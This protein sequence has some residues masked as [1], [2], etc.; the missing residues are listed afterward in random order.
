VG[1]PSGGQMAF[2]AAASAAGTATF[3]RITNGFGN[4]FQGSVGVGSGELQLNTLTIALGAPIT[5]TAFSVILS[6]IN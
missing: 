4:R 5:I 1:A 3:F 2:T 6:G